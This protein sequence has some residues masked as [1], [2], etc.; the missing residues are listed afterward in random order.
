MDHELVLRAAAFA[1]KAHEK[2]KRKIGGVPYINH[3]IRV[4]HGAALAGL[5]TEA[6]AAALLHDVVEDT[7]YTLEDVR[8]RFPERVV[9]LVHLLTQT[10]P[11]DAPVAVKERK[12]PA[13]Y[14]AIL[15]DEEAVDLKLLDRAD[16]LTDMVRVIPDARRWAESYCRRTEA[17]L[18][19]LYDSSRN[20]RVRSAYD[21]ALQALQRALKSRK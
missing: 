14:A 5:S 4:A 6:V 15:E 11:D 13:Y 20:E 17:E 7:K 3:L 19:P 21:T 12:R 9:R 2:Q 18:A 10:W 1:A 8:K 16:N